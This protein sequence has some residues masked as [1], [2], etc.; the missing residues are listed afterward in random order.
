MMQERKKQ[1]SGRY[2]VKGEKKWKIVQKWGG[3]WWLR[4]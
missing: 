4:R 2:P 3:T 1:I